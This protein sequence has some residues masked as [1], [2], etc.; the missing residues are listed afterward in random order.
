MFYGSLLFYEPPPRVLWIPGEARIF[1][2]LK[3]EVSEKILD[4]SLLKT[5][6]QEH[7]AL[8]CPKFSVEL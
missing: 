3:S 5:K 2:S 7:P 1:F 4:I 8:L 6:G